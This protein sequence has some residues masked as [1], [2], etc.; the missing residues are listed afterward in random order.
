MKNKVI[1]ESL[2]K[3]LNDYYKGKI[4][5]KEIQ[6][7][8]GLTRYKFRKIFKENNYAFYR[9]ILSKLNFEDDLR[10]K[11]V[12]KYNS[13]KNRCNGESIDKYGHYN[14]VEYLSIVEWVDY[15]N[16]NKDLI[17]KMWNKYLREDKEFKYIISIDR[18]T[19]SKGYTKNNIQFV[20]YG[21]NSWKDELIPLRVVYKDN[22]KYCLS[23]AEASRRLGFKREQTIGEVQR[24]E[25]SLDIKVEVLDGTEKVLKE[26]NVNS[27]LDYY[28]KF[29]L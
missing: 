19:T 2:E 18:I 25:I 8:E 1:D 26:N 6:K 11:L 20:S 15:C 16:K 12:K 27:L 5:A 7:I 10:Y 21:F 24:N 17:I 3:Y 22:I 28:N 9:D 4:T 29:I 14:N 23:R 13:I